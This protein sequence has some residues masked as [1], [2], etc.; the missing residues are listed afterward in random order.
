MA[1][2]VGFVV[3]YITGG[4]NQF[5]DNPRA[6][7]EGKTMIGRAA[8][9]AKDSKCQNQLSQVRQGITIQQDPVENT[10]PENLEA[11]RL[12]SIT[13]CPIGGEAYVYDPASGMVYCPHPGHEKY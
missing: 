10:F 4:N 13:A 12:G 11:L 6:D 7:R 1:L 5:V 2:G 8:A 9:T 3:W